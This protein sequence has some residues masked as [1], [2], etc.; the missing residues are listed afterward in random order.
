MKAINSGLF[1]VGMLVLIAVSPLFAPGLPSIAD[2]PIHLFRTMEMV[3]SWADG[4]YYPR[5]APNLAFGYG[6]PLFDFAP[7][8]PYYIA[9]TFHIAGFS[10]EM[11]IKLLSIICVALYGLGMYLF[12]RNILGERAALLAAAA[13]VY[14]PFRFR[15]ILL[16]GGN[17]PQILAIGLFPWVLW[18]FERSIADGRRRYIVAGA[19]CYGALV[20]SHIFHAFIFTPLLI[21]FIVLGVVIKTRFS[22]PDN[23]TV[24]ETRL[25][26]L[27]R[28]LSR[29]MAALLLGL[30][31][32]AFFWAPALYDL[33]YTIAQEDYYLTRS[34]F[35]LRLLSF[36]DLFSLPVPLDGRADN[37]YVPF[38]LGVV[39]VVLAVLGVVYLLVASLHALRFKS[40][41]PRPHAIWREVLYLAFFLLV[42]SGASFM[43]LRPA[44]ILWETLPFLAYAEF[45][46][47]LM[48]VANLSAAFLAGGSVRLWERRADLRQRSFR[49]ADF[50]LAA[51]LLA[52]ILGVA[53][54]LYPTKSFLRWG[55][56][57]LG[58]YV[59]YETYSQNVG[60]TG[61]AEYLPRWAEE[62]PTSSPLVGLLREGK[63]I[64]KLNRL[65]LPAGTQAITLDHSATNDSYRFSGESS[66]RAEFFT[67]F[68]PGWQAFLDGE[69][70]PIHISA[71][72]GLMA[73]DV[74]AGEH[75]LLLRFGE[76]PFRLAMD[77]ISAIGLLGLVM[78][79]VVGLMGGLSRGRRECKEGV[80]ASSD[81]SISRVE[82]VSGSGLLGILLMIV[83]VAKIGFVDPYTTWFRR[84]SPPGKVVAAQ[85][86]MHIQ[87]EDNV[88][89][90]GYDLVGNEVVHAGE[91]LQ[92]RLYWQTSGPLSGDYVSFVHLDAPPDYTTFVTA[93]NFQPG[94]PQAQIDV[95][96]SYWNSTLYVRDE[97]RMVLPTEIPPIAYA[98]RAGLYDRKTGKR[99]PISPQ[100]AEQPGDDTIYLQQI[101][102]LPGRLSRSAI[103]QR[104]QPYQLGEDIEL[105]GYSVEMDEPT[106][107]RIQPDQ[108]IAVTLFWQALMPL[109]RDYTVFVQLLD[110]RGQVWSQHDGPPVNGRY[111][112]GSWL[113]RQIVEDKHVLNLVPD[114]PSGEY[115]LVVGMYDLETG[116]RLAVRGRHGDVPNK[117]ILLDAVLQLG[118]RSE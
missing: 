17:Y 1:V 67:F 31:L 87:L 48:G 113:P 21:L 107:V 35:R 64:E 102:V 50:V 43:M 80:P 51:S 91:P 55:T 22:R 2:A 49:L 54:Y 7:P 73:V 112:T 92:V 44:A 56:P 95:P 13:N 90:L 12:T 28:R 85:H 47:R 9:G 105:L 60:T 30:V 46:W 83:F 93:D 65:T 5:W 109:Q 77:V 101:H 25:L 103:G 116:A 70:V 117:A 19:L 14:T 118:D 45:P 20:L 32:T 27:I 99:L 15:E 8:L 96:S 88:L 36:G 6:Y 97:H 71:P 18:A 111:L 84:Q 26:E 114:L 33:K 98:L 23:R 108:A 39:V 110:E 16:Y 29:P 69:P 106:D 52:L 81:L 59:R 10:L 82:V 37:P 3:S 4:V 38:S 34:D 42:L 41:E 94:D 75:E 24:A 74:P 76:T 89:F 78:W 62:I 53:V 68:F 86:P 57:T 72:L 11:S 63:P 100:Q 61:L 79:L 66:F 58:D 115:H 40:I 104:Q